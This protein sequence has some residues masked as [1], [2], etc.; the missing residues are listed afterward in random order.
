MQRFGLFLALVATAL[1]TLSTVVLGGAA[2]LAMRG[3]VS[4]D[5]LSPQLAEALNEEAASVRIAFDDTVLTYD[6]RD[7]RLDIRLDRVRVNDADGRR[8]VTVPE[9]GLRLNARALL[10]QRIELEQVKLIGPRVR[11]VRAVEGR[12]ELAL[13]QDEAESGTDVLE[14]WLHGEWP[15]AVRTLNSIRIENADLVLDDRM[16]GKRW[17]A[18]RADLAFYRGR[19]G[20]ALSVDAQMMLAGRPSR[21]SMQAH[22]VGPERPTVIDAKVYDLATL[23]LLEGIELGEA[24]PFAAL[25]RLPAVIGGSFSAELDRDWRLAKL[26][27]DLRLRLADRPGSLRVI[28]DYRGPEHPLRVDAELIGVEPS[29]FVEE[30]GDAA[31]AELRGLTLP[32]S[33]RVALQLDAAG[34]L[35][36]AGFDLTSGA[37]ELALP[38]LYEAPVRIDG[39]QAA[40][41]LQGSAVLSLEQLQVDLGGGRRAHFAGDFTRGEA[42]I[43]VVG[44]GGFDGLTVADLKRYWPAKVHPNARRWVLGRVEKGQLPNVRF[45]LNAQPG[46]FERSS[47]REDLMLLTFDFAGLDCRYWSKMPR[48]TA[49]R[50]RGRIDRH[51]VDITVDAGN[52]DD[53]AVSEG[54]IVI[55]HS[56][57]GT[58]VA[59]VEFRSRGTALAALTLL[60]RDPLFLARDIGIDIGSAAGAADVSTHLSV[61]LL[62]DLK[63]SQIGYRATAKLSDFAL[64]GVFGVYDLSDGALELDV[65]RDGISGNGTMALEGVPLAMSWRRDFGKDSDRPSR[66]K[67]SGVLDDAGRRALRVN[68]APYVTGSSRVAIDLAEDRQGRLEAIGSADLV[69]ARLT[70][71]ALKWEKPPGEPAEAEFA[72]SAGS[73]RGGIEVERFRVAGEGFAADGRASYTPAESRVVLQRLQVDEQ[74]IGV[75]VH[76]GP[77]LPTKV[78]LSGA[79]LDLR[80]L[81]DDNGITGEADLEQPPA[82]EVVEIEAALARVLVSDRFRLEP[83]TAHGRRVD[84]RWA[85]LRGRGKLNGGPEVKIDMQPEDGAYQRL[86]VLSTDAGAVFAASDI[87]TGSAEGSFR[88]EA[89]L[90]EAA[91]EDEEIKGKIVAKEFRLID[92]PVFTK[93]LSMASVTGLIDLMRGQGIDFDE[94][95]IAFRKQGDVIRFRDARAAGPAL[96][97]TM[98]GM[99]DTG[100]DWIDFEGAIVPAYTLNS[101]LGGIPVLGTLLVGREGEGIFALSY[102]VEGPATDPTVSVNP[103]SALAPGFLRRI[104]ELFGGSSRAEPPNDEHYFMPGAAQP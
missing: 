46:D 9:V 87:L 63:A 24:E 72:F 42:G 102:R 83:A 61:P 66:F 10:E 103:L 29:R 21:I 13:G 101:V 69:E 98:S 5:F 99:I 73:G 84:G 60:D 23:P 64:A 8:L 2:V 67:L 81:L 1:F 25:A 18:R 68:L 54:R 37:G 16:L 30:L 11:V 22:Y 71:R 15:G 57:P 47:R 26:G 70:L 48:L 92:A 14:T 45:D 104:V 34:T 28:G 90:P 77:D 86:T 38:E 76:F 94:L 36:E 33:G 95:D 74:D 50:G 56:K 17:R 53:I 97:I 31:P 6:R 32:L 82:G 49:A 39:A 52:L 88:L 65:A 4:L 27:A 96:G 55:D 20:M 93:I 59:E 43:G 41:R 78:R 85:M 89:R 91:A 79:T 80:E 7:G 51:T 100:R 40:G 12:F 75:D 19:F 35:L 3:H 62:A 44:K 58:E